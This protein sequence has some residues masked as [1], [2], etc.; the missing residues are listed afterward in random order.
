MEK[1][2]LLVK[3]ESLEFRVRRERLVII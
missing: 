2:V 1:M 3:T